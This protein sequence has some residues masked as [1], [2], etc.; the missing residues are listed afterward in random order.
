MI[1][2]DETFGRLG[3]WERLR[4]AG[5]LRTARAVRRHRRAA[6]PR[7]LAGLDSLLSSLRQRLTA[8]KALIF[9]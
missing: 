1:H 6:S 3:H 5:Q 9:S 2:R 7:A 8:A 4:E